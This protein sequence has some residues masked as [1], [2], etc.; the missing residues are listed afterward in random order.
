MCL[1]LIAK[2]K[3]LLAIIWGMLTIMLIKYLPPLLLAIK[4]FMQ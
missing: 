1:K 4:A 2:S 3:A